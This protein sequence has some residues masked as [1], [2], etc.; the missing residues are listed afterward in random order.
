M[1]NANNK[2]FVP[3][4]DIQSLLL[5]ELKAYVLTNDPEAEVYL[6]GSRARQEAGDD[7]DWDFFVVTDQPNRRNSENQLIN[8]VYDL[9]LKFDTLIQ[10][11]VYSKDVYNR[12]LSPNPLFDAVRKEGIKL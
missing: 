2:S 4:S 6:F 9:M 11:L 5:R 3:S 8:G 7:S 1:R 12:G 10:V